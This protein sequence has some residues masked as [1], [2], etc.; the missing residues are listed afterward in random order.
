[1]PGNALRDGEPTPRNTSRTSV[2]ASHRKHN[3]DECRR[4]SRLRRGPIG[5]LAADFRI[6][7]IDVP[8][9]SYEPQPVNSRWNPVLFVLLVVR[10]QDF[11]GA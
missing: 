2:I 5:G 4:R 8:W 10:H 7:S 6:E 9:F 11:N 3:V 1:M